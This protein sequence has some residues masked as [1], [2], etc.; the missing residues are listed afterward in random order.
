MTRHPDL[1]EGMLTPTSQQKSRLKGLNARPE[2]R[3]LK[4]LLQPLC[5][6]VN[7]HRQS[8]RTRVSARLADQVQSTWGQVWPREKVKQ[9]CPHLV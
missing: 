3:C 2:S 6:A 8:C 1:Q 5:L 7:R 4:T 9:T